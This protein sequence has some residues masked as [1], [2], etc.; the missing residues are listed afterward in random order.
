MAKRRLTE[1]EARALLEGASWGRLGTAGRWGPY[2]TPLHFVLD[3]ETVYF[4]SSPRGR[5]IANLRV[6]PRVCFEVSELLGIEGGPSP[7]EF[8]TR[9]W[10]V[11]V[12]GRARLV[13][14]EA[15]KRRALTLL[16]DR[17][18]GPGDFPPVSAAQAARTA[19]I[20]LEITSIS[21]RTTAG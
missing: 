16:A 3:G 1:E 12:F 8:S 18:R 19:V 15:E 14:D 6:E 5:K 4:H 10:S 11:Q 13:E 2:V 17:F 7:C 20:A 9:F 21:G